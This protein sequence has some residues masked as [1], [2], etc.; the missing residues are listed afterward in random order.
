MALRSLTGRILGASV[1]VT[2]TAA[3][4]YGYSVRRRISVVDPRQ[5]TSSNTFDDIPGAFKQSNSVTKIVNARNHPPI[6]DHRYMTLDI[7]DRMHDVSDEVLLAQFVKGF[8]GGAVIAPE[9]MTLQLFKLNL[10]HYKGENTEKEFWTILICLRTTKNTKTYV[11]KNWVVGEHTALVEHYLVWSL[12]S[13]WCSIGISKQLETIAG[14]HRELHWFLFR[15]RRV[16]VWWSSSIQNYSRTK[17][18]CRWTT[19]GASPSW[20]H[21]L[22]SDYQ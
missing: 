19:K 1:L 14:S 4:T 2:I 8:F 12:S 20:E 21:V 16:S 17:S 5:I 6:G 13:Q 22:Q 11:V 18:S 15:K 3:G 9:R 10:V 7:P